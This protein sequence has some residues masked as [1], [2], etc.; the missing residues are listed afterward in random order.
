MPAL[1]GFF[2]LTLVLEVLV[3]AVGGC[4]VCAK[5]KPGATAVRIAF[6]NGVAIVR[7]K[8]PTVISD[9]RTWRDMKAASK[10]VAV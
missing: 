3:D 2:F 4:V 9:P 8:R 1:P 7:T 10:A 5:R 6:C